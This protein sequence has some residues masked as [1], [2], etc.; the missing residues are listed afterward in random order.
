MR[1]NSKGTKNIKRAFFYSCKLN[2]R[3]KSLHTYCYNDGNQSIC[4][5]YKLDG[6]N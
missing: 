2:D 3:E 1:T 6:K 5:S 4:W